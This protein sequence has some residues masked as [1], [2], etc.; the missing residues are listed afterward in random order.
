MNDVRIWPEH[1]VLDNQRHGSVCNFSCG[2]GKQISGPSSARCGIGGHWSEDVNK[3]ICS[4]GLYQPNCCFLLLFILIN[5][6]LLTFQ[7]VICKKLSTLVKEAMQWRQFSFLLLNG[8][9]IRQKQKPFLA[10]RAGPKN[11]RSQVGQCHP[12]PTNK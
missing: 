2:N 5:V 4:D 12:V 7:K 6:F 11:D 10:E 3:V 8:E 1:C 9:Q